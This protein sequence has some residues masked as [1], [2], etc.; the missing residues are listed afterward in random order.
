MFIPA[1][2]WFCCLTPN[3]R[4]AVAG[5]AVSFIAS[6]NTP[7]ERG[8]FEA[9]WSLSTLYQQGGLGLVLFVYALQED[10][11]VIPDEPPIPAVGVANLPLWLDIEEFILTG[12]GTCP[13]GCDQPDWLVP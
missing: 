11:I 13:D 1:E 4:A 6:L 7:L 3:E 10:F 5:T 2:R 9:L 12:S 8:A